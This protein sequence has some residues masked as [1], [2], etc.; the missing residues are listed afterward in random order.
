[1]KSEKA[2]NSLLKRHRRISEISSIYGLL[3][4]DEQVNLPPA[5][6]PL[7]GRQYAVMAEWIHQ[8]SSRPEI[9]DELSELESDFDN[10]SPE[11]KVVVSRTR[12]EYD[13]IVKI[14]AEFVTRKATASSKSYQAWVKARKEDDFSVFSPRLNEQLELCREE[15]GYLEV[16]DTYDYYIDHFDP[17]MD[18]AQ[19]ENLFSR[20]QNDLLP[21]VKK[22][23]ESPVQAKKDIFRGFPEAEQEKFLRE[24]VKRVGFDF[25]KGR[26]D[27]AVHP[28]CSGHPLDCRMTTRFDIDNPLDSWSSALHETG[29]AL[30]EQ[31]LPEEWLDTPMG[32]AVGMAIHESQSRMWEN[33]IGRSR[34]FWQFWEPRYRELFPKQLAYVSSDDL[35]LA[36]NKV[37]LTPI[38]VDADEVTYNL[39]ILL[40]FEIEKALFRDGLKVDDLPEFWNNKS[41]EILGFRPAN[42]R[43]GCLQDVHWSSGSFGY[44]P[45]YCLG[46]MLA[47]QIWYALRD[48][49]PDVDD[50]I[51]QAQFKPVLDWLRGQVHQRGRLY[52]TQELIKKISGKEL[53]PEFLVRY[54]KERYLPLYA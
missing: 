9:G 28:F 25:D 20:L 32:Q 34:E 49:M 33:Q 48:Q 36:I 5:S 1:M 44:F 41:Q 23:T 26:I 45:S 30:Y 4:W 7:R 12:K 16:A 13:R 52:S 53:S 38:R 15:A 10:L 24:V 2:W 54:L 47:A 6:S 14:P 11:Q 40:R 27:T 43:E 50:K 37:E 19:I 42:N 35:Y 29:H 8:E 21:L 18:S 51:A 39:H 31:G 46:N 17:G 22:I 3:G